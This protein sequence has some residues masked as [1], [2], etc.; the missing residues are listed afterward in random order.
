[1]VRPVVTR[2]YHYPRLTLPRLFS[3]SVTASR[4]Q[5]QVR[6]LERENRQLKDQVHRLNMAAIANQSWFCSLKAKNA[7]YRATG[8]TKA[9]AKAKVLENCEQD[10]DDVWC[11]D[12]DVTCET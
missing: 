9:E 12:T 8:T 5:A 7:K 2:H 4:Q 11:V 3:Y 1:M 6:E 10:L